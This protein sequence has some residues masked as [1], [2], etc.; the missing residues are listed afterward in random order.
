M[1]HQPIQAPF[2]KPRQDYLRVATASPEVAIGDVPAN[3][4]AI[5]ASYYEAKTEEAE[6]VVL[7]E[8]GLTGYSTADL[9]Q[10]QHVLNQTRAGL[11]ALAKTTID[12]PAMIVGAP[13]I[14]N[15][16]L[17]NCGVV[18]AEGK[19][20]GAVPKS[21]LPNYKEF[22]EARWFTSGRDV[23]N[24]E[25]MIGGQQVPFGVDVIFNLNGTKLGIEVCEDVFAPLPP[26][27]TLPLE[28]QKS[29]LTSAL[30]M[31]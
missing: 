7:P 12:G 24:Q 5:L 30:A 15:D 18:L 17:Y 4:E 6:L 13:L 25:M 29:S 9:F 8:L 20:A 23:I 26:V 14:H 27:P 21:Y 10:N 11:E 22:Y 19:I 28:A 3:I 1:E 16:I 31:N 2:E